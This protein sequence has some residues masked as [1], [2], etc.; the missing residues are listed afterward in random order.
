MI[1]PLR[2]TGRLQPEC[3]RNDCSAVP[4]AVTV[5]A[6]APL[7]LSVSRC[8]PVVI[9][10]IMMTRR[11]HWQVGA[12]PTKLGPTSLYKGLNTVTSND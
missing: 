8:L 9:A 3:A 5:T 11:T 6:V 12:R 1:V 7:A 2:L 4:L 10:G